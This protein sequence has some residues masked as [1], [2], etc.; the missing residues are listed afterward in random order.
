[1]AEVI[2]VCIDRRPPPKT[3]AERLALV[4]GS[5]WQPGDAIRV[6]FMDGD[7]AVQEKVKRV[8]ETWTKLANVKFYFV[9]DPKADI[10]ISFNQRGSWSYIGRG[11]LDVPSDEP[12]MNYGWLT[13]ESTDDEVRR[14]VLHEFGHALACIHEHQ[15]PAG[16]INWNKPAVYAYFAGPPNSWP[17]ERVDQNL[18]ATYS[19]DLTSYSALDRNSIMMYPIP[20]EFTL[21]GFEVGLN[22][23][24]SGTDKE[25]IRQMYP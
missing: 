24:L 7:P 10:R 20:K 14:V 9:Q 1:M 11:C 4:T 5:K 2:K 25:F 21:D 19:K 13:P 12:T 17:K 6:V 16:G 3:D 23:D 18:F 15:N 8:A 22:T